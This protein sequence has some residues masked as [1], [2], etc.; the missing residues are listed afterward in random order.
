MLQA[1]RAMA[2]AS[3]P[4]MAADL[5]YAYALQMEEAIAASMAQAEAANQV[6]NRESKEVEGDGSAVY[7]DQEYDVEVRALK[8]PEVMLELA[9]CSRIQARRIG[10]CGSR[11]GMRD[12]D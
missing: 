7:C 4:R 3:S 12:M 10:F 2:M 5:E 8:T 9:S 11:V 1:S 6:E